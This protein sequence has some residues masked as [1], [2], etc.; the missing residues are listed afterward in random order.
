[1]PTGANTITAQYAGDANFTA[2]TSAPITV[3]VAADFDF[4]PTTAPITVTR[5]SSGTTTFTIAG[6]TG[7]NST[8]NFGSNSCLGLPAESS[9]SFAPASVVGSGSTVLTIKTTAPKTAS[10]TPLNFWGAASGGIFTAL[11]LLGA[12]KRRRRWNAVLSLVLFASLT[13]MVGCG[14]GGSNGPPPD[15]GTPLGTFTVTVKAV[16]SLGVL[17]HNAVLT[18]KVQ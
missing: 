17:S 11:F 7:Y 2:S 3:N 13:T 9:C 14:G 4:T 8:I 1:L 12:S 16:D 15:P 18:L 5:G 10:L 6:H